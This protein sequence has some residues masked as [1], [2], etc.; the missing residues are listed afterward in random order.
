MTADTTNYKVTMTPT[1]VSVSPSATFTITVE[2][3]TT[4][5]TLEAGT[6][7]LVITVDD[8]SGNPVQSISV[9]VPVA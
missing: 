3:L 5:G 2:T 9:S 4:S 7:A 6:W 1:S 8:S